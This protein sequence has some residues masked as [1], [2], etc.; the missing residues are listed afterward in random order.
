M[1]VTENAEG[2]MVEAEGI[3]TPEAEPK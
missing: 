2:T 1:A 3:E